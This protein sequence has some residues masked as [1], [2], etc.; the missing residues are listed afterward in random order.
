LK[1]LCSRVFGFEPI[2]DFAGAG[3][4]EWSSKLPLVSAGYRVALF[5][6]QLGA[7]AEGTGLQNTGTAR[8]YP[9]RG[10]VKTTGCSSSPMPLR[11]LDTAVASEPSTT[12]TEGQ[13]ASSNSSLVTTSPG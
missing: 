9:N 6:V 2:S 13:T 3:A 1:T 7:G 4:L 11:S 12:M 5:E 8:R 10:T